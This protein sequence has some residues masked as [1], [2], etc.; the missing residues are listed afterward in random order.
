[1]G[2]FL[3]EW[4]RFLQSAAALV[5][6]S[7]LVWVGLYVV[8]RFAYVGYIGYWLRAQDRRGA[9]TAR[10]GAA[11]R[12]KFARRGSWLMNVD[13]VVLGIATGKHAGEL[14]R[15]QVPLFWIGVALVVFGIA[16]T[17]ASARALGVKAWL[18]QDFFEPT[19]APPKPRGIYRW[20]D[21]PKYVLGYAHAYGW[22]LM[23]FSA[24]GL[25]LSLFAHTA[26]LVYNRVVERP[27]YLALKSNGATS[28]PASATAT[29]TAGEAVA[30][31]EV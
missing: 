5:P 21:D 6:G 18:W 11:A 3:D 13:G 25:V 8:A 22:A 30:G 1:V 15:G 2:A 31:E 29:E 24:T 23:C 20:V 16:V 19:T 14:V 27:H 9:L 7:P 28:P 12:E 17:I 10:W 4:L 26:I